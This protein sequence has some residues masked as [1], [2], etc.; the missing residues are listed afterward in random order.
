LTYSNRDFRVCSQTGLKAQNDGMNW[1][2]RV[3]EI[4]TRKQNQMRRFGGN[5]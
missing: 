4:Q 2:N 3:V 5:E 1:G